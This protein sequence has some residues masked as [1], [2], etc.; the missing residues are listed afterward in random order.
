MVNEHWEKLNGKI[1]EAIIFVKEH[2][3][4]F[5][6]MPS[7]LIRE[8][9]A[10]YEDSTL[11]LVN[12]KEIRGLTMYQEWPDACNFLIICLPFSNKHKN[13]RTILSGRSLMPDKKIVWFDE[14]KMEGRGLCH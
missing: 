6:K 1:D 14:E 5:D 12:D 8:M 2:Y 3:P 10:V 4:K 7:E 13:L 9:F 11:I